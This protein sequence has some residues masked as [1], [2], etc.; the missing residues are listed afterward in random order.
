M[1]KT[2]VSIIISASLLLFISLFEH[3]CVNAVFDGFRERL[4][5]LYEKTEEGK[6]TFCDGDSVRAFWTEKRKE[7]HVWVTHTSIEIRRR[8]AENRS[9]HR[10]DEKNPRGIF[11]QFRKRVL[12]ASEIVCGKNA[13]PPRITPARRRQGYADPRRKYSAKTF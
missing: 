8:A 7:L 13:E 9:A 1:V 12:T 6:A 3:F 4:T 11:V 5:A 2:I 10:N